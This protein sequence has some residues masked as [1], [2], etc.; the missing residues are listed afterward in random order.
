MADLAENTKKGYG[1]RLN[2]D[3][4]IPL[5]PLYAFMS[6]SGAILGFAFYCYQ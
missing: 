3:G 4:A 1:S 2:V 5:L 6:W